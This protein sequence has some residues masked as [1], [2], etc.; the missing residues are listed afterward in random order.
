MNEFKVYKI[1]FGISVARLEKYILY[2]CDTNC[3][4]TTQSLEFDL[5][6]HSVCE[7]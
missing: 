2:H 7:K 5:Y 1:L 4:N 3:S 6:Y